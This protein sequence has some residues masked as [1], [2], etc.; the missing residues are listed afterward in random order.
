MAAATLADEVRDLVSRFPQPL[1]K[2]ATESIGAGL[3]RLATQYGAAA[4]LTEAAHWLEPAQVARPTAA[5]DPLLDRPVA[6]DRMR[7]GQ[8]KN[9]RY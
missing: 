7:P 4:V 2:E 6:G 9:L 1:T 8:G 3:K 5:R